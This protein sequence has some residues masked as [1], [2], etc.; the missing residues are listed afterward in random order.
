MGRYFRTAQE[1]SEQEAKEGHTVFVVPQSIMFKGKYPCMV[2]NTKRQPTYSNRVLPSIGWYDGYTCPNC[3]AR[4]SRC[5]S[6]SDVKYSTTSNETGR[7][8][9]LWTTGG[10]E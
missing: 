2:C 3:K 5:Y 8:L 4:T 10:D 6:V 7:F 9:V 1:V